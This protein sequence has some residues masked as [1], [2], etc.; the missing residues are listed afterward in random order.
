MEVKPTS[1]P[2]IPSGKDSPEF[3]RRGWLLGG[4]TKLTIA[5]SPS[6][7]VPACTPQLGG[8]LGQSHK[9]WGHSRAA[10]VSLMLTAVH[11]GGLIQSAFDVVRASPGST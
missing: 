2:I 5:L 4:Q 8:P 1:V 3:H 9:R 6:R 11:V 7:V 10:E